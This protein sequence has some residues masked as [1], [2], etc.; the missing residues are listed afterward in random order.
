M[1]QSAE[2]L[3]GGKC[4]SSREGKSCCQEARQPKVAIIEC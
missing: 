4:Y 1:W 2:S 3:K